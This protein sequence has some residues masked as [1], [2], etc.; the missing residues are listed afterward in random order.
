MKRVLGRSGI[1]VSALGMGCWAIGGVWSFLGSPGGWGE[2]DDNESIAALHAAYDNGITFYDTAANYGAGHSE[3]LLAKAFKDRRD[4]V[5][6]AT[7]FGYAV[8]EAG[9]AVSE[10]GDGKTGDVAGHLAA[11][12]E[13]SLRRLETDVI[14]LFQF[15][16]NEYDAEK[17]AEVRD[18]LEGLVRQGKIRAY[19]W[20]TDYPERM[21][22]FVKGPNCTSV[23]CNLNVVMRNPEMLTL[24]DE[25]DQACINR[26]PLAM[27]ILTGKYN[28]ES[29]WVKTDVRSEDWFQDWM[30]EPALDALSK[31]R[32]IFTSDGR[33]L[34]QGALAWLWGHS[35]RTIPI[36]GIR[37]VAQ[38]EENAGAM[39]FGPLT[40]SQMK[41][42]DALLGID[43]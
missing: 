35:E 27:G 6:I 21:K 39:R 29:T 17:S 43:K 26:A 31:V 8:D 7:K 5:V 34:A 25:Y 15:H 23:Q 36:P 2:T 10:Y 19:G 4:R 20:S 16:V 13:A 9:K 1:E 22:V 12:V 14:D 33:T 24:C 11:D 3:H 30:F 32:E 18:A 42:V 41:E 37:T 28:K 38:A 40:A